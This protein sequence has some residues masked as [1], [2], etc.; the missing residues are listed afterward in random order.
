MTYE[1]AVELLERTAA[2]QEIAAEAFQVARGA[3]WLAALCGLVLLFLLAVLV[4]RRML[5]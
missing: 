4:G 2:I 1:Q 3:L 5:T